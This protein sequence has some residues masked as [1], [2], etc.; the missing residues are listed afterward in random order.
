LARPTFH[1]IA[2][3]NGAGKTTFYAQWLKSRTDAEFVNPDLLVHDA[4]GRW[5]QTRV[6]AELG[7][8]LAQARR[9]ALMAAGQSLVT[10]STFSHPSKLG[11][12]DEVLAAGYRVVVYHLSVADADFA[13]ERVA[14]RAFLGG[15]P[16]PEANIRGR[17]E[18][19]GPLI[20]QAVLRAHFGY[21]FDNSTD[22]R[23]PRLL[24][25]FADGARVNRAA[26]LPA[27]AAQLYGQD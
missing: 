23:P 14:D 27:W 15:H 24:L 12:V 1:L 2:G 17:Y 4:L 18:R 10:E 16:V 13:V 20:R 22:G 19:S 21:V 7:Q 8:E 6:D 3:P 5:S 9:R 11:L 25:S 26:S